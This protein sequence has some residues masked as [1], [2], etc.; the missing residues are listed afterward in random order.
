MSYE[1]FN[2]P[3]IS[4]SDK[5]V[6]GFYGK[7]MSWIFVSLLLTFIGI[8]MIGPLIPPQAVMWIW[9]V[10]LIAL[11]A[12]SFSRKSMKFMGFF[13]IILPLALG[14]ILYPTLNYYVQ[15][16]S[17]DIIGMAVAGTGLIF[18]SMSIWGWVSPKSAEKLSSKLFVIVLGLIGVSLLNVFIFKLELLSFIISLVVL[19]VFSIYTFIDIQRLR[20]R[21][22]N[23]PASWYALNIYL[24]IYN[25]FVSLLNILSFVRR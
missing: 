13:V 16:G 1:N 24:N 15:T 22:I 12:A 10:S 9:G 17:G 19:V 6:D 7:V 4:T 20:D 2:N 18:G 21:S 5:K 25:I 14:I 23:A 3:I 11:I 8:F